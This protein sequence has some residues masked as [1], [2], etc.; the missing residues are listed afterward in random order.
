MRVTVRSKKC[1]KKIQLKREKKNVS[2]Q[3]LHSGMLESTKLLL[4]LLTC[5]GR[6]CTQIFK[7]DKESVLERKR[8]KK[9]ILCRLPLNKSTGGV[10]FNVSAVSQL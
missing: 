4:L 7:C 5:L 2:H 1:L 6:E 10:D 3:R 9:N 8:K